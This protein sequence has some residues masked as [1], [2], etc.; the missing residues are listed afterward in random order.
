MSKEEIVNELRK[1]NSW[2][3]VQSRNQLKSMVEGQ[4]DI[5]K[6]LIS[7]AGGNTPS[8]LSAHVDLSRGPVYKRMQKMARKGIVR[9]NSEGEWTSL[10]SLE[11]LNIEKPELEVE[12]DG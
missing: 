11:D 9:K 5:N 1:L 7:K 3:K 8:E 10:C 4:D 2:M 6:V 12:D